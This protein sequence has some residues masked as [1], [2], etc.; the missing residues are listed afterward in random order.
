MTKYSE[1]N[2]IEKTAVKDSILKQRLQG[3]SFRGIAETLKEIVDITNTTVSN[4]WKNDLNGGAID[5]NESAESEGFNNLDLEGK[6]AF[7]NDFL[8]S[9]DN[10]LRNEKALFN[11]VYTLCNENIKEHIQTG[12]RIKTSYLKYL[13]DLHSIIK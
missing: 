8:E 9:L 11:M 1:L 2:E 5:T 13:K 3:E 7:C 10:G 6:P 12:A 4:I